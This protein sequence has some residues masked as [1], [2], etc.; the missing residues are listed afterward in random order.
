MFLIKRIIVS[1]IVV[2]ILATSSFCEEKEIWKLTSLYWQP[3][4]GKDMADQGK[5]IHKLRELLKKENITLIVDFF[6]WSRS[7]QYAKTEDYIGYFPAWVEEIDEGFVASPP[8]DWSELGVMKK[9]SSNVI[10]HDIDELFQK[11]KI[12]IIQTYVYPKNIVDAIQKYPDNVDKTPNEVS[13]VR[14]LSVGRHIAAITDP[15]V[16]LYLA[17]KEGISDIETIKGSVV[18]K[19]LVIAIKND[20]ENKKRIE[21]LEKILKTQSNY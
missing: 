19:A 18:K 9:K 4:S 10:F 17:A 20:K 12:G 21:L 2:I 16:M 7:K 14:K 5:S 15:N 8:V 1:T 3:Y 6:P 13:L 11:Y